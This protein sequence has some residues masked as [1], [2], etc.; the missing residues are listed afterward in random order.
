MKQESLAELLRILRA[1]RGLSVK[2]AS[3]QIGVEWHTL[4]DLELGR[5]K[6]YYPTLN[7]IAEGYGV[8]VEELLEEPALSGKGK[9]PAKAVSPGEGPEDQAEEKAGPTSR[10]LATSRGLEEMAEA[11][12]RGELLIQLLPDE[13]RVNVIEEAVD[14]LRS[15]YEM[16][17]RV[18]AEMDGDLALHGSSYLWHGYYYNTLQPAMER[19][20]VL[21]YASFVVDGP[22]E[23]SSRERAACEKIL[24]S[25]REMQ[26][27]LWDMRDVDTKNN[28][29]VREEGRR[30]VSEIGL[31][32]EETTKKAASRRGP[33]EQ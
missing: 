7:K 26:Y 10:G 33:E 24:N 28:A 32:L 15:Y 25:D 5:R 12:H 11:W 1:R 31:W 30:G 8:P 14:I 20:G 6:A 19:A 13:E 4:R 21:M 3:E 22:A 2:Q 27:L 18:R 9:A 17:L 29:R 16:G 23:V